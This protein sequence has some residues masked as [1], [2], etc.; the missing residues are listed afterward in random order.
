MIFALVLFALS[1][2]LAAR[3]CSALRGGS[4]LTV[5][6]TPIDGSVDW[7][8]RFAGEAGDGKVVFVVTSKKTLYISQDDGISWIPISKDPKM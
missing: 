6:I 7:Q 1:T 2:T 5:A 3:Q 4:N 8:P